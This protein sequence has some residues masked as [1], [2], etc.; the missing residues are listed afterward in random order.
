MKA[1]TIEWVSGRLLHL[2]V[3]MEDNIGVNHSVWSL[4][5]LKHACI[6]TA[7]KLL[8]LPGAVIKRQLLFSI[9]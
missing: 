5:N 2:I 9:W 4:D 7:L 6:P 1:V 8:Y 3:L